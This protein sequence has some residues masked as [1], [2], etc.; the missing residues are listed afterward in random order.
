MANKGGNNTIRHKQI[1]R[2]GGKLKKQMHQK[3][4]QEKITTQKNGIK[5]KNNYKIPS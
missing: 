4:K 2:K 3:N 5:T 1:E